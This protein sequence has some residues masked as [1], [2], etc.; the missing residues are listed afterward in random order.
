M[1]CGTI[2]VRSI[3]SKCNPMYSLRQRTTFKPNVGDTRVMN[4][5]T[6]QSMRAIGCLKLVLNVSDEL[7]NEHSTLTCTSVSSSV[8]RVK[9]P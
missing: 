8:I 2:S 5:R 1:S 4:H 3:L 9:A 6:D 7:P